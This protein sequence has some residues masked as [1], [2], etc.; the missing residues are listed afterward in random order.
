MGQD[1]ESRPTPRIGHSIEAAAISFVPAFASFLIFTVCGIKITTMAE[2][3]VPTPIRPPSPPEPDDGGRII[4]Q[5]PE[6]HT[7]RPTQPTPPE[8]P[9]DP[10]PAEKE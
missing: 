10:P 1:A 4:R 2:K 7:I 3:I 5:D 8:R 9:P 6:P